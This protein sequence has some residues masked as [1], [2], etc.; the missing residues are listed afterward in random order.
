MRHSAGELLSNYKLGVD[1]VH[2]AAIASHSA[3]DV[4]DGAKDEEFR[5][6]A[7]CQRGRETAYLRF[8]R[9]VDI[10]LILD[11]YADVAREDVVSKLRSLS[12]VFVPN[13]SFSVYVATIL[14][15]ANSQCPYS[16]IGT[17]LGMRRGLGIRRIIRS[18]IGQALGDLGL[19]PRLTTLIGP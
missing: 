7:V 17:C 2:I 10:P 3:L 6:I 16:V 1:S 14:S 15:R 9:V 4:F 13:R 12:T 11:K 18:S 5:T 19:T 8:R